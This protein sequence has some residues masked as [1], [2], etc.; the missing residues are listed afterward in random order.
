MHLLDTTTLR[1]VYF[2]DNI[3]PYAILS[4]TW[5][6]DE[7]TFQDLQDP[8][9][10]NKNLLHGQGYS[11]I[12]QSCDLAR[13]YR[14]KYIWI[15]TCCIN[16]KSSAELSEA[17]NSMFKYYH[18]SRVCYAFL[19]DVDPDEDP[20]SEH[21]TFRRSRWFR[22]GWTLQELIA[23]GTVVFFGQRGPSE[24]VEIGT[25]ASLHDLVSTITRIP[26]SVLSQNRSTSRALAGCS[27][28]QKMSWAGKRET[29][30]AEDLAYC[31]MGIFGVHMPP[32]YG[33]GGPRAFMRLQEQII[34]Y[35]D[36]DTIFAWRA[37]ETSE[38]GDTEARGL[39]ARSPSEF[40][41]S[42]NIVPYAQS[43]AV[44]ARVFSRYT[45][46]SL[47]VH[48]RLPLLPVPS[49]S[50]TVRDPSTDKECFLIPRGRHRDIFLAV[51]NCR[52]EGRDKPLALYL[53]KENE[54]QYV[55][56]LPER[57]AIGQDGKGQVRVLYVKERTS[58]EIARDLVMSKLK[59]Y[60]DQRHTFE[61]MFP[62][63]CISILDCYPEGLVGYLV[64]GRAA[65]G[66]NPS[67]HGDFGIIKL[68]DNLK[69][70]TFL[71]VFGFNL[72]V[73]Y[74]D[75]NVWSDIIIVDPE[76]EEETL[77]EIYQSYCHGG[78]RSAIRSH[79]LDRVVKPL[80]DEDDV[81]MSVHKLS[82]VNKRLVEI[83]YTP[84][85]KR[86]Q[87]TQVP[88][89]STYGFAV[90]IHFGD[91]I[92][93][94][95]SHHFFPKDLWV[96]DKSNKSNSVWQKRNVI[97][98]TEDRH[99]GLIA[100]RTKDE[101]PLFTI[102]LGVRQHKPLMDV[103]MASGDNVNDKDKVSEGTQIEPEKFLTQWSERWGLSSGRVRFGK[104][105]PV[106]QAECTVS[107]SFR[108][109]QDLEELVT[110][111]VDISIDRETKKDPEC[112]SSSSMARIECK[113]GLGSPRPGVVKP[114]FNIFSA[115]SFLFR[116]SGNAR[117]FSTISNASVIR[118]DQSVPVR[119][120]YNSAC[121]ISSSHSHSRD[122]SGHRKFATIARTMASCLRPL[123]TLSR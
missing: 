77:Q 29:T 65:A 111:Y 67:L 114:R 51:L 62:H 106:P 64:D 93:G 27:V 32:L 50:L 18:D 57:L 101:S 22:R 43:G 39:F 30:R 66:I 70:R 19:P 61:F 25:K 42:G 76:S 98:F 86:V 99:M 119:F 87:K 84:T 59:S 21:S 94:I 5:G 13:K 108:E 37:N 1:L 92:P 45:V 120:V 16:K 100:F 56:V 110:H 80:T 14:F 7:L 17:I 33:E 2:A 109:V 31:L 103:I 12:K 53:R 97:R 74:D 91:W 58:L 81:T 83:G 122:F 46:T 34:K 40:L 35:Y 115:F 121:R 10:L 47:G 63:T 88:T 41:G 24:W 26:F 28:A 44:S 117:R 11:K 89:P 9:N 118:T 85:I 23:P 79:P 107:A 69:A 82:D 73:P 52:R 78:H 8:S 95:S 38:D 96:E 48:M 54:L 36:D 104:P 75:H 15:D 49:S 3:P 68:R 20:R 90:R 4:H 116:R 71:V 72:S 112:S 102:A 113:S 60:W 123:R 105:I 55:R 6:R